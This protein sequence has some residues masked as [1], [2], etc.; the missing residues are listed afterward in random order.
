[1]TVLDASAGL[2]LVHN[3][4][5]ADQVAAEL[6]SASLGAAN[7]GCTNRCPSAERCRFRNRAI[8]RKVWG[9]PRRHFTIPYTHHPPEYPARRVTDPRSRF[10]QEAS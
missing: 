9:S 10:V 2:A 5:G 8:A 4:P 6:H 3:E 1:M 7:N